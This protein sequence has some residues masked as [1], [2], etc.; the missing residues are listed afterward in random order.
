VN[1]PLVEPRA[2]DPAKPFEAMAERIA[3]NA[4]QPFGGAV[5]IVPPAGAAPIE[6]LMLDPASDLAMFWATIKTKIEIL[7]ATAEAEKRRQAGFGQR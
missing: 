2:N 7:L 4:S 6:M 3:Q 1:Q 5:V